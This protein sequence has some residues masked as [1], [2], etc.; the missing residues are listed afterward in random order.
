MA[1]KTDSKKP[2]DTNKTQ[3]SKTSNSKADAKESTDIAKPVENVTAGVIRKKTAWDRVKEAFIGDSPSS[4]KNYLLDEVIIPSVKTLIVTTANNGIT[5]LVYGVG[6]T[7]KQ[8]QAPRPSTNTNS[9]VPWRPIGQPYRVD[10]NRPMG[11][12]RAGGS[13]NQTLNIEDITFPNREV[14][15]DVLDQM[16]DYIATN[17]A[18]SVLRYYDLCHVRGDFPMTNYGWT[19]TRDMHVNNYFDHSLGSERYFIE[20]PPAV[21][22]R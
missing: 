14:A 18:I 20:L 11:S 9:E 16:A 3:Y 22:I 10:Y 2:V 12:R 6:N 4:V 1:D 17:G 7:P 15:L 19:T 21:Q 8:Q 5:A 13:A